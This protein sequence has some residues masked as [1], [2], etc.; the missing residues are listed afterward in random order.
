MMICTR[1][2][3]TRDESLWGM[4]YGLGLADDSRIGGQGPC[5]DHHDFA[6]VTAPVTAEADEPVYAGPC[7]FCGELHCQ[8]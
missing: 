8:D 7:D 6:E 3:D 1:C 2:G 5:G 4:T